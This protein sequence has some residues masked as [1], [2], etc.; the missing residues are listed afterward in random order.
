MSTSM[1]STSLLALVDEHLAEARTSS[2]GRSARTLHG[3]QGHVLRQTLIALAAH[4]RLGEHESPGEATL[5]VLR[6]RVR[7]H[8]G[9]ETW[10][11]DVG[12]LVVIPPAR[13]DLEALE[14]AAV[15]LTV[16]LHG[17]PGA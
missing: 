7:L 17:V 14:D 2:S 4:R 11:G 9:D 16:A 10:N 8:A 6:G 13:H 3:G 15:L 12:D 1:N 5:Q